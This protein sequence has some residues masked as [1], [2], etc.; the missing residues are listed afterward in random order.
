MDFMEIN[1][2]ALRYDLSGSGPSTLVLIHEMGGTLES[3]DLARPLFAA[4]RSVLRYD[5]RGAGLSQKVRGALTIDTMADDLVSLM[6]ALGIAGKVA[7]A[8]VAVGGAMDLAACARAVW[9]IMEHVTRKG[10]PRLLER[11]TLPLTAVRCVKR[12]YTDLAVIDIAPTGMVVREMLGGLSEADLR[13][14]TGAP[15][16]FAPDCRP[17]KAPAIALP[18]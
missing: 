6:D 7:L 3:W 4:K 13:A 16:T 9:V 1:G 15:L 5:T 11:C 12:V 2:T 17:L 14:R 10:T 18:D 8:G